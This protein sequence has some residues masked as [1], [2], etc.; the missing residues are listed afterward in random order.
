MKK[1][2][3]LSALLAAVMVTAVMP[4]AVFAAE[5]SGSDA[6][7]S[8]S[9]PEYRAEKNEFF[10]NGTP[11]TITEAATDGKTATITWDGGSQEIDSNDTVYGGSDTTASNIHLASTSVTMN[12][13]TVHYIVGGNK[14]TNEKN[15]D[16]SIIDL[17]T[18]DINGGSINELYG[19]DNRNSAFGADVRKE[20]NGKSYK[21]YKITDLQVTIDGAQINSFRGVTSYAYAENVNVTLG[22]DSTAQLGEVIWGT[23]GVISNA[24]FTMY[25]GTTTLAGSIL[26]CTILN[27]M[28]YNILGGEVGEIYAGSYYPYEETP[29]GSNNWDGWSFGYVDYGFANSIEINIAKDVV[30]KDIISG[31]QYRSDDIQVFKDKYSANV[32]CIEDLVENAPIALNLA[33]SPSQKGDF[34]VIDSDAD[35]VTTNWVAVIEEPELPPV[36]DPETPVE[37]VTAG[38]DSEASA[39]LSSETEKLVSAVLDGQSTDAITA[40]VQ[41]ALAEAVKEGKAISVKVEATVIADDSSVPDTDKSGIESFVEA[42]TGNTVIAQYL[43]LKVL[44]LAGNEAIGEITQLSEPITFVLAIPDELKADGRVFTVIRVHDGQQEALETVMN[45]DGTIS[46]STDLFST[47]ALVYTDAADTDDDSSSEAENENSSAH[48]ESEASSAPEES[49]T[50]YDSGDES[51]ADQSKASSAASGD[52]A[53]DTDLPNTGAESGMGLWLS[54]LLAGTAGTVVFV[55]KRRT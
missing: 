9:A 34:S 41:Q 13:G 35:Y 14:T 23:N 22:Q 48:D 10:A 32:W 18:L 20:Q 16:Y 44:L 53:K 17:V 25:S 19:I 49:D 45:D 50:S 43:D 7:D 15:C 42:M 36:I 30:Y 27:K 5:N 1:K 54:L 38:L 26:R 33:S 51:S 29:A 21:N 24:D 31:F 52:S 8:A 40:E 37:N 4:T 46:F 6:V 11:I 12:G 28:T 3:C 55:K 2:K 47:Y 39:I